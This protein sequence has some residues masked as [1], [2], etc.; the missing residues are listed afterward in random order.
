[1][2]VTEVQNGC[3]YRLN[4]HLS[5]IQMTRTRI[6]FTVYKKT[7]TLSNGCDTFKACEHWEIMQKILKAT[8]CECRICIF[9]FISL[10]DLSYR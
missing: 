1:M 4:N 2:R 8:Y 3:K 6:F 9:F 7:T 10:Y 5:T